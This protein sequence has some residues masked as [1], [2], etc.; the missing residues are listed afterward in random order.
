MELAERIASRAA[1]LAGEVEQLRKQLA[2]AEQ[3]LERLVIAGQVIAQL[4]A[5]D[6]AGE[7][8]FSDLK[9]W[10]A[11]T[12]LRIDPARATTLLRALL[13]L[14]RHHTTR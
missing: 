3:E 2:G 1:E 4:A 8:A 10:R 9:H 13:V 12:R 11:L 7:H 5:D 6:A 14:T